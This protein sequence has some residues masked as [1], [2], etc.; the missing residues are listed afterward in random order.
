MNDHRRETEFLRHCIRYDDTDKRHRL[1]ERITRILRDER[2]VRRA[3]WLMA[4][5]AA[6][7]MA[8]LGYSAIFLAEYPLDLSQ[9]TTLFSIKALCVVG[10]GSL[11]C[12]LA[13]LGLGTVYRRE[14]DQRREECRQLF[15]TIMESRLGEPVITRRCQTPETIVAAGE[16][17]APAVLP[18][19]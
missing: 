10:A 18:I 4:L 3:V 19:R 1:E 2:C 6:L 14:L 12:L 7:A 13:F 16:V 9:L 15:T 8:G 11:I 5:L 17:A